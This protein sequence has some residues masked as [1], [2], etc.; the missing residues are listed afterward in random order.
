MGPRTTATTVGLFPLAAIPP[1]TSW[2][3][4]ILP[5]NLILHEQIIPTMRDDL[6]VFG[7]GGA[8]FLLQPVIDRLAPAPRKVHV[9]FRGPIRISMP[10]DFNRRVAGH[11]Y[12]FKE[13]VQDRFGFWTKRLLAL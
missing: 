4:L 1:Q 2:D 12:L 6:D 10:V 13:L 8:K 7:E 5:L 9:A 3:L 11:N